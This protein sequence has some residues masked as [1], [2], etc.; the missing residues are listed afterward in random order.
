MKKVRS[1]LLVLLIM[2]VAFPFSVK[3]D[4]KKEEKE[5]VKEPVKVYLFHSTSC[6]YCKNA[7][8]WFKSIEEEYGKYFDLVDYEV[9]SAENSSLWEEAATIMGDQVGGVPYMVVGEYS[10]PNGFASDTV[11]D[12]ETK[13]TMGDQLIERIMETYES[14]NRYDVM[15]EINNKPSY[16]NIVTIVAVVIIAGIVAMTIITRRQSR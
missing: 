8:A 9:S 6:G 11:I 4:E 14:D 12:T 15:V 3:A 7:L 1:L 5:E 10:Y 13:K 16:D 2:L